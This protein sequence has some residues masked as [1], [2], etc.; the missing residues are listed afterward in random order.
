VIQ[1]LLFLKPCWLSVRRL[2]SS[3]NPFS[4][5]T[6][7]VFRTFPTILVSETGLKLSAKLLLLPGFLTGMI[8]AGFH[9]CG[10]MEDSMESLNKI[11]KGSINWSQ[12]FFRMSEEIPSGPRAASIFNKWIA[13]LIFILSIAIYILALDLPHPLCSW[14]SPSCLFWDALLYYSK[15]CKIG[16]NSDWN[17]TLKCVCL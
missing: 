2:F 13:F 14:S 5:V 12:K 9:N 10:N 11:F 17:W 6:R 15:H 7:I 8:C 16:L 4:S 1:D 3:R